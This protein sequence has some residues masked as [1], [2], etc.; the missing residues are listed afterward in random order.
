MDHRDR[1]DRIENQ[2]SQWELQI[3]Q[4]VDAYLDYR[5]QDCT[6]GIPMQS[7]AT[8]L[9]VQTPFSVDSIDVFCKF[10][11]SLHRIPTDFI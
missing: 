3:D 1:R 10:Y 7:D 11:S 2:N 9:G 8:D 4:L 6:D 5:A